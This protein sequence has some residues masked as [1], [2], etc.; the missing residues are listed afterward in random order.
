MNT[1]LNAYVNIT[2]KSLSLYKKFNYKLGYNMDHVNKFI[3]KILSV[4][5]LINKVVR[6]VD[7]R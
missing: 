4:S 7:G 5:V 1:K 2:Y 3:L 6:C